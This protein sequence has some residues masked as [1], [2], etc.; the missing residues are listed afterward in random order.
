MLG[1]SEEKLTCHA[2]ERFHIIIL[3]TQILTDT[4]RPKKENE[5]V[6]KLE[7]SIGP[8]RKILRKRKVY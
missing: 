1:G 2:S 6:E 8:I 4:R 5:M 3:I 7:F